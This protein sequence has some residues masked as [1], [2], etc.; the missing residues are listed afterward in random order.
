MCGSMADIQSAVAENRRGKKEEQ[1]TAWKYIWS[2]LF[3]RATINK[4][5]WSRQKNSRH[6]YGR[7]KLWHCHPMYHSVFNQRYLLQNLRL[8]LKYIFYKVAAKFCCST[9]AEGQTLHHHHDLF[10]G[11]FPGQPVLAGSSWF[12]LFWKTSFGDKWHRFWLAGCSSYHPTNQQPN[13]WRKFKALFQV[14]ETTI[15]SFIHLG[16]KEK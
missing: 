13:H 12:S 4:K 2:V 15:S 14:Q 16:D 10:N 6:S 9:K 5:W 8:Q 11:H 1:T 3:H 7:K